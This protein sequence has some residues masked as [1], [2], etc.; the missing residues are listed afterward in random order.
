M[1][2]ARDAVLARA[3]LSAGVRFAADVLPPNFP[4]FRPRPWR[5]SRTSF[6]IRLDIPK[7]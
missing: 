5:Y 1:A 4:Y 6:G 7:A 2:A 3:L